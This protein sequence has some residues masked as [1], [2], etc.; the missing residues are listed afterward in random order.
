MEKYV[1]PVMEFIEFKDDDVI[2]SSPPCLDHG[3]CMDKTCDYN[4][5]NMY[6]QACSGREYS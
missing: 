3:L 6:G 1:V 5:P 2:I 4:C